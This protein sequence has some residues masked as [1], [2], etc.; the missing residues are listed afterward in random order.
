[1]TDQNEVART[2]KGT[3]N[4]KRIILNQLFWRMTMMYTR[5]E[6]VLTILRK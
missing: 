1:M 5:K 3:T 2:K 6:K 4:K